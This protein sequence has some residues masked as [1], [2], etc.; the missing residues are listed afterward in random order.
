MDASIKRH[1][2]KLCPVNELDLLD[3]ENPIVIALEF[4]YRR[5]PEDHTLHAQSVRYKLL[6]WRLVFT[7]ES[8]S[9]AAPAIVVQLPCSPCEDCDRI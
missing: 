3:K 6:L 4:K 7:Q 1:L 9:G 5:A 8:C 2:S